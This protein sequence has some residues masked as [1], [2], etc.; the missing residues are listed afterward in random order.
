MRII[1]LLNLRVKGKIK[2][3]V[4]LLFLV[5]C[6]SYAGITDDVTSYVS[7][8][9]SAAYN[10]LGGVASTF[11]GYANGAYSAM[12]SFSINDSINSAT[13]SV[14]GVMNSFSTRGSQYLNGSVSRMTN[15]ATGIYKTIYSNTVDPL[16][17]QTKALNI[18]ERISGFLNA[19]NQNTITPL[20]NF[21]N[22][23]VMSQ[24]SNAYTSFLNTFLPVAGGAPNK[25]AG[26]HGSKDNRISSSNDNALLRS[27]NEKYRRAN[28]LK[29]SENL[30]SRK[31]VE[32]KV[33]QKKQMHISRMQNRGKGEKGKENMGRPG[34]QAA[35]TGSG[36]VVPVTRKNSI[37]EPYR[38]DGTRVSDPSVY[39]ARFDVSKNPNLNVFLRKYRPSGD[40]QKVRRSAVAADKNGNAY[41]R[42]WN[43]LTAE[44]VTLNKSFNEYAKETV[45]NTGD[46]TKV[47]L[48]NGKEFN[49]YK[50]V[51]ATKKSGNDERQTGVITNQ[52]LFIPAFMIEKGYT[53]EGEEYDFAIPQ[54]MDTYLSSDS[55]S[56]EGPGGTT[57]VAVGYAAK[58][59][60]TSKQP[61]GDTFLIY[62]PAVSTQ[63]DATSVINPMIFSQAYRAQGKNNSGNL[64]S[65][66]Q[67]YSASP[68]CKNC[69]QN[70]AQTGMLP[71]GLI[72]NNSQSLGAQQGKAAYSANN[73][74]QN[75]T[76]SLNDVFSLFGVNKFIAAANTS[77]QQNVSGAQVNSNNVSVSAQQSGYSPSVQ[78][79]TTLGGNST[80][81]VQAY[82]PQSRSS[83]GNLTSSAQVYSA[84]PACKDC[85]QNKAQT[86]MLPAGLIANNSQSLVAQQ[87]NSTYSAN[88]NTQSQNTVNTLIQSNPLT[89]VT[90]QQNSTAAVSP[91][92]GDGAIITTAQSITVKPSSTKMSQPA[93][94]N[95]QV[96]RRTA[97]LQDKNGTAYYKQFNGASSQTVSL[98]KPYND[99]VN[100]TLANATNNVTKSVTLFSG[101]TFEVAR[102]VFASKT[103]FGGVVTTNNTFIPAYMID[104]GITASG[105]YTFV[106]PR[107][108]AEFQ[109]NN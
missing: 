80:G 44:T 14:G 25:Q 10:T 15:T 86:G 64:T 1:Q 30:E 57:I 22:Q 21:I 37:R 69:K 99:Y 35:N 94:Q 76:Q 78:T 39:N 28:E 68:A 91:A 50:M 66:G 101:Q 33:E 17:S 75:N 62:N 29:R 41:Y 13:S 85:H 48:F 32:A 59:A 77:G 27:E 18:S 74:A 63:K 96:R 34:Q 104:K 79:N 16:Q 42:Q 58:Y 49:V 90:N 109:N 105:E 93:A 70:K 43:G 107:N 11:S 7:D 54:N 45:A 55:K 4:V 8:T 92:I 95:E 6:L 82:G 98:N 53:S 31:K 23:N 84:D 67:V 71:A 89:S 61:V 5:P 9:A 52:N 103:A 65:S 88:N 26:L 73:N 56:S 83:G 20:Y 102:V 38:K 40:D 51:V 3:A 97:V 19:F 46:T 2:S 87:G 72:V 24:L 106:L 36:D 100:E 81:L 108:I 60:D 47:K 12:T